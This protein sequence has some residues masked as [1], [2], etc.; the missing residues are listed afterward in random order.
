[1]MSTQLRKCFL[2]P[3]VSVKTNDLGHKV[4]L[5]YR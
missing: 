2:L 5:S 1:M 3:V 4:E